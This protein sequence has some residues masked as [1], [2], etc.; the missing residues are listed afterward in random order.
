[1]TQVLLILACMALFVRVP[2]DDPWRPW[3]DAGV[4][5]P[6]VS[7]LL[8]LG[9]M[10]LASGVILL[11][12]RRAGRRMDRAGDRRAVRSAERW[13]SLGTLSA[14]GALIAGV[15]ALG[16]LD[17]VRLTVGN[18]VLVDEL[19]AL[20]PLLVVLVLGWWAHYPIER[21][22]RE[23][24]MQRVLDAGG[25]IRP[26]ESR[27][28]NVLLHVRHEVLLVLV[29]L[30]LIMGWGEVIS[31][32]EDDPPA[33]MGT[34]VVAEYVLG[35]VFALGV[36]LVLS[37]TPPLLRML[38]DTHALAAGEIRDR[39]ERV[40]T[41]WRVR[42][43]ELLLWRTHYS[44]A[45]AAVMGLLAPLR[46][47]LM[48][49]LLLEG[50][51]SDEIEAVAAHEVAHVRM[52]HMPWL[53]GAILAPV[54]IIAG[55]SEALSAWIGAIDS[56]GPLFVLGVGA[57]TVV[58]LVWVLGSVSRRFEWQAD[59]FAVRHLSEVAGS[60]TATLEA[61]ESMSGALLR[62]AAMGGM[63]ELRGSWRH[64]SIAERRIRLAE[65][66]GEPLDSLS[67]DRE[68]RR[69]KRWIGLACLVALA[70]VV[71]L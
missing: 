61:A 58:V 32:I 17:A 69:A 18:L 6:G 54:T 39:I 53:A 60:T 20:M 26:I 71:F 25:V 7:A 42:V 35:G 23:A 13:R 9:A 3:L 34:G 1:M 41:R 28:E 70:V 49:D 59:A 38:W 55:L 11:T 4:E 27:L 33:W 40:C 63:S 19:I 29:P 44:M 36:F 2:R 21:R 56:D 62:V 22:L 30:M 65:M 68:V 37:V 24:I 12:S 67:I 52:R 31:L 46:Y 14:G 48:T 45:N 50:L 66:V 8:I 10:A 57:F 43:R 47:I 16:W 51:E 5:H 64:G 15:L